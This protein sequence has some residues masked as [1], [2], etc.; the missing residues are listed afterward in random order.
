MRAISILS[1]TSERGCTLGSS[2][3]SPFG[4]LGGAEVHNMT[5]QNPELVAE[6]VRSYADYVKQNGVIAVP[7][8]YN[9][10]EQIVKNSKRE[11][12]H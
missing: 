4:G 10:L 1:G 5:E 8:G 7:E 2:V 9:P 6:L 12:S 3:Q 11:D